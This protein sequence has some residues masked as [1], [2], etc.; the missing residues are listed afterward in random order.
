MKAQLENS[1]L[2]TY[3]LFGG[4]GLY[5]QSQLIWVVG[6]PSGVTQFDFIHRNL[7]LLI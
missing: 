6:A 3:L 5:R 4:L 1:G 7:P 2:Q